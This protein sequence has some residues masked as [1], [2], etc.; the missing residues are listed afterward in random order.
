MIGFDPLYFAFI[1]PGLL[2]SLWASFRT[3]AA[4]NK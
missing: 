1:I 2:L 3:K 4:F